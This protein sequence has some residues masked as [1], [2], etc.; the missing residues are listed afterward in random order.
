MSRKTG[1]EISLTRYE[2]ILRI[3]KYFADAKYEIKFA[4]F[5]ERIFHV[6]GANIS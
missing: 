2:M 3:M 6:C 1:N 4:I 5:A